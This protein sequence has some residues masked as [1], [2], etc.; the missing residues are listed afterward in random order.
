M[1]NKKRLCILICLLLVF[2]LCTVFAENVSPNKQVGTWTVSQW[3]YNPRNVSVL[4]MSGFC[5][6][7]PVVC[8]VGPS[9]DN[10][11]GI[12]SHI[13]LSWFYQDDP[14]YWYNND[15]N[16]IPEESGFDSPF[17]D[18]AVKAAIE[19]LEQLG[20]NSRR[21]KAEP[22]FFSSF[23]RF[24]DSGKSRKVVFEETL[25]GLPVRWSSSS[26]QHGKGSSGFSV[27]KCGV[28]IVFSEGEILL[29]VSGN[30]CS[31]EPLAMADSLLSE[32]E[33]MTVFTEAGKTNQVPEKCWF[34]HL[35]GDE[36]TAT[37]AWRIG[38]SYVNAMDGS[39]LQTGR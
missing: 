6:N 22:L 28:E 11:A 2:S 24:Q 26:L 23:G 8:S 37:L 29:S 39:W 21:W 36:A 32:D 15:L 3:E 33:I 34:L 27:R 20:L 4:C 12:Q 13:S 18:Q 1:M 30:W 16:I 14:E 25:D 35:N 9:S 7:L 38:N 19:V 10:P 31:F 17:A 5:K